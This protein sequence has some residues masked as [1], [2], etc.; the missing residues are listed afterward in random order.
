M[1]PEKLLWNVDKFWNEY[2]SDSRHSGRNLEGE[3]KAL[4]DL[5]KER[6][7]EGIIAKRKSS[8]YRPGKRTSDWLKIKAPLTTGFSRHAD[9]AANQTKIITRTPGT[10]C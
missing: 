4:F 3:G 7:M 5:T 2:S 9:Q 8:I 6:G 10:T 1:S